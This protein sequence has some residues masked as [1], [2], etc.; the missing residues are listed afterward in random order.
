MKTKK[1]TRYQL[2]VFN[3]EKELQ[4][5]REELCEI[6]HI[7]KL[8][9]P[10]CM[11]WEEFERS[12]GNLLDQNTHFMG[13]KCQG[14]AKAAYRVIFDSIAW[15]M[16]RQGR[17]E[18]GSARSKIRKVN[19]EMKSQGRHAWN[20]PA[21]RELVMKWEGW[22]EQRS[23]LKGRGQRLRAWWRRLWTWGLKK[24]EEAT[25]SSFSKLGE[26]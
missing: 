10:Q 7:P 16:E 14:K 20:V 6:L 4:A 24:N 23:L 13:L 12:Q 17:L 25:A 22:V 21:E 3:T 9:H 19:A 1:P 11:T 26:I 15:R 8:Q 18:K 5:F 2:Y